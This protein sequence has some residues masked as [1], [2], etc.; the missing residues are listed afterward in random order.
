L[1]RQFHEALTQLQEHEPQ[2]ERQLGATGAEFA[3]RMSSLRIRPPTPV[4]EILERS[5]PISAASFLTS[6]VT[7]PASLLEAA[8][9]GAEDTGAGVGA[10]HRCSWTTGGAT[11]AAT[12]GAAT[13][14]STTGGATGAATGA[15]TTGAAVGAAPEPLPMITRTPPT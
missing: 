1:A 10:A 8:A 2:L 15:S 5:I 4:P 7:Y 14:A 13:G 3:E 9:T 12:I 11:G 6:G